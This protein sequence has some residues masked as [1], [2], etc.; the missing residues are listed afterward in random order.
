[1]TIHNSTKLKKMVKTKFLSAI[2]ST[3]E[4]QENSPLPRDPPS[5]SFLCQFTYISMIPQ[6]VGKD[7]TKLIT[8]LY[9]SCSVCPEQME[10][11]FLSLS[12]QTHYIF[13]VR[14]KNLRSLA[15]AAKLICP[16]TITMP[17]EFLDYFRIGQNR[18][19]HRTLCHSS[20]IHEY[21]PSPPTPSSCVRSSI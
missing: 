10:S 19:R 2:Y 6:I 17:A 16:L 18:H 9:I 3:N 8:D 12:N 15:I 7:P 13:Y 21:P 4:K 14:P 1:M 11:H 20:A 5:L